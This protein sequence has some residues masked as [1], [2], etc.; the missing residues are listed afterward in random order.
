MSGRTDESEQEP[1]A[2][3]GADPE[4]Q[5]FK[6]SGIQ[7]R[8]GKVNA[9]LIVVYIALTIWGVWYLVAYWTKS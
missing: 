3:N 6:Y 7:E 2:E 4:I 5:T 9:W 8:K 1:G